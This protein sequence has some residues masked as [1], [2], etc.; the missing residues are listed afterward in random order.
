MGFVPFLQPPRWFV[1]SLPSFP[2]KKKTVQEEGNNDDTNPRMKSGE[3][4]LWDPA[5][6]RGFSLTPWYAMLSDQGFWSNAWVP[7]LLRKPQLPSLC[8]PPLPKWG[9][10]S[11]HFLLGHKTKFPPIQ[12]I[13]WEQTSLLEEVLYLQAAQAA[14]TCLR[15]QCSCGI[16]TL[17]LMFFPWLPKG[18]DGSILNL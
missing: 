1:R 6:V 17:G 15:F 12:V 5:C 4:E 2:P 10:K 9:H 13:I 3:H 18:Q 11:P 14:P 8:L 7:D 16:N